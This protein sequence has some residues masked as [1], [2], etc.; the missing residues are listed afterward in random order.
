[1]TMKKITDVIKK[2]PK[3]YNKDAFGRR[4]DTY[5]QKKHINW[6]FYLLFYIFYVFG[7]NVFFTKNTFFVSLVVKLCWIIVLISNLHATTFTFAEGFIFY[8]IMMTY[9]FHFF[10]IFL[11]L[12]FAIFIPNGHKLLEEK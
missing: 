1:M 9:I 3:P 12:F 5:N 2:I 4:I 6:Y 7:M 10:D 11:L 8:A